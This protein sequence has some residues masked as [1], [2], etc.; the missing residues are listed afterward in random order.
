[1]FLN[2]A[3]DLW[4]SVLH[5]R[6]KKNW[7]SR[8]KDSEIKKLYY[9]ILKII[10]HKYTENNIINIRLGNPEEHNFNS[11]LLTIWPIIHSET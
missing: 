7:V 3:E 11:V 1:M 8:S 10:Y 2:R 6:A 5:D 9:V 4:K